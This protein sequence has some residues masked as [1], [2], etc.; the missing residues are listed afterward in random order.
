MIDETTLPQFDR[1]QTGFEEDVLNMLDRR[2]IEQFR[3]LHPEYPNTKRN[4]ELLQSFLQDRDEPLPLS[5]RN[6]E[7]AYYAL[8]DDGQLE[9]AI[10]QVTYTEVPRDKRHGITR[11]DQT[12]RLRFDTGNMA[13]SQLTRELPERR[14][15]LLGDVIARR[16]FQDGVNRARAG[17]IGKPINPDFKEQY[18]RSLREHSKTQRNKPTLGYNAAEFYA[19]CD[20]VLKE[21]PEINQQS[22]TFN[23]LVRAKLEAN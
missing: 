20:A 5:L 23:N 14:E 16:Q 22:I 9:P 18:R 3:D 12:V 17:E 13:Q 11:A 1:Y 4:N 21:H 7:I 6:L 19:A 15:E 8:R 2:G 10:P